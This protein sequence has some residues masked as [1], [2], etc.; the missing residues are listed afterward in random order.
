M[1]IFSESGRL[2]NQIFQYVA[3]RTLC[4]ENETLLLLGFN[5]LQSTFTNLNAQVINEN[6]HRLERAIYYRLYPRLQFLA[7]K[8]IIT[9]INEDHKSGAIITNNGL[10]NKIA[11]VK[12]SYFQGQKFFNPQIANSLKIKPESLTSAQKQLQ[13]IVEGRTPIFVHVRRGDY[14]GWPDK[15][16]PAVLPASYYLQCINIINSKVSNPF[17]I[18]L[19]DDYYYIKDIFSHLENSYISQGTALEDFAI[20]NLCKGGILSA[21]TF[22]WWGSYFAK[23]SYPDSIFLAPKHWAGH[24]KKEWYPRYIQSDFLTYINV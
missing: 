14:L 10:L 4:K 17:F 16:E 8:R 9:T 21:S 20:M 15:N 19:S 11:L 5:E 18:F 6:T 2:G 7:Q 24:R 23:M 3:L 22:T 13:F 1:L 12:N